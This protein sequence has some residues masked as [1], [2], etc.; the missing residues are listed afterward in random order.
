[1]D[2]EVSCSS[3]TLRFVKD[4]CDD[5]YCQKPS[6]HLFVESASY[7]PPLV[8]HLRNGN[9]YQKVEIKDSDIFSQEK[10]LKLLPKLFHIKDSSGIITALKIRE[11]AKK[12]TTIRCIKTLNYKFAYSLVRVNQVAVQNPHFNDILLN[13]S[14][15][16]CVL[17]TWIAAKH[18]LRAEFVPLIRE[19]LNTL[20]CSLEIEVQDFK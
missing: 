16:V 9:G 13:Y 19:I 10:E 5:R 15:H 17:N 8:A 18:N 7:L 4:S 11:N 2:S 20:K 1:R 6:G 3:E 14:V 12:M